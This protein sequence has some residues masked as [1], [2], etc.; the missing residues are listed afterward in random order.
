MNSFL[1]KR[2]EKWV[3]FHQGGWQLLLGRQDPLGQ[4]KQDNCSIKEHAFWSLLSSQVRG[5]LCEVKRMGCSGLGKT[6]YGKLKK[7]FQ[8]ETT[9]S[10][11]YTCKHRIQ[12]SN[13]QRS[14]LCLRGLTWQAPRK[15][16]LLTR[17][18]PSLELCPKGHP[19]LQA[20][21][22]SPASLLYDDL[23]IQSTIC[24]LS[25]RK[26]NKTLQWKKWEAKC[27]QQDSYMS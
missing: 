3:S 2:Q 16:Q 7:I 20:L 10:K 8:K 11:W 14:A 15:R 24:S 18:S 1:H 5:I 23:I 4:S 13:E 17:A 6:R 27:F 22:A 19:L 26:G 21:V 12:G 25:S 9:C